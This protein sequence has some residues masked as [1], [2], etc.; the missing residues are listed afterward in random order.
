M[1]L[2][3]VTALTAAILIPF[4]ILSFKS[5]PEEL[6]VKDL[7]A[8]AT[9]NS[10]NGEHLDYEFKFIADEIENNEGHK[11]TFMYAHAEEGGL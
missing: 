8:T 1:G 5:S 6:V 7:Q 3:T 2:G 9:G 4:L 10:D 11:Y